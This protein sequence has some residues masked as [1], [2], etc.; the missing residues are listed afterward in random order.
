MSE[1]GTAHGQGMG[2]VVRF[3]ASGGVN[4]LLT[5]GVYYLLLNI[6]S[7]RWSYTVAY[8]LGIA[9]AYVLYRF[10]VF[11]RSGGRAAP[12]WVALIYLLQ[13]LMG[14][15][16]VSLWVQ[17]LGAPVALAPLFAVAVSLPLT[18]LLNRWVFRPRSHAGAA[19]AKPF[20][21]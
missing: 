2:S 8:A 19:D 1:N 12:L 18:Y 17:L 11:R 5:W 16:L 14:L 9:L 15:A 20:G 10:Y 4:T 3:L 13:Y 7:Y 21:P 6:L